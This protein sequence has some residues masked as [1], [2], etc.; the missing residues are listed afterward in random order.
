MYK[1]YDE[2]CNPYRHPMKYR[3]VVWSCPSHY[4]ANFSNWLANAWE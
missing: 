1:S 3:A 2:K 4:Y